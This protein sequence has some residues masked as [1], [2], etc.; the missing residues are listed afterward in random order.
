MVNCLEFNHNDRKD[1]YTVDLAGFSFFIV[2]IA[3]K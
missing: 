3:A 1:W 2:F